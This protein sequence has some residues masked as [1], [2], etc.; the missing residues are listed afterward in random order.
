MFCAHFRVHLEVPRG[1]LS[2]FPAGREEGLGRSEKPK[3]IN[4]KSHPG[5]CLRC[6]EAGNAFFMFV[7]HSFSSL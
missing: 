2:V 5:G 7:P 1:C 6:L 3:K 4:Q